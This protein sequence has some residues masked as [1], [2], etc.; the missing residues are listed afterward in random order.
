VEEIRPE[1]EEYVLG[2]KIPAESGPVFLTPD[3]LRNTI[4]ENLANIELGLTLFTEQG[5]TKGIEYRT[6]VGLIDILIHDEKT[7]SL[8]LR[9]NQEEQMNQL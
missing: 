7:T 4:A 8:L 1:I 9:S 5:E 2:G 3:V 6:E